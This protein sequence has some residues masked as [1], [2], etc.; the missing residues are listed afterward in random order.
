MITD[1]QIKRLQLVV[2]VREIK[3]FFFKEIIYNLIVFLID[4][5]FFSEERG[6]GKAVRCC[7]RRHLLVK[8]PRR[9]TSKFGVHLESSIAFLELKL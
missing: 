7:E 5:I 6:E 8:E 9:T 2:A 4:D 3:D 1:G